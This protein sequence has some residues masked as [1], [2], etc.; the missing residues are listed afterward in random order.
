L[1]ARTGDFTLSDGDFDE[2]I[3]G[4]G[5]GDNGVLSVDGDVTLTDDTLEINGSLAGVQDGDTFDILNYDGTLGGDG[6]FTNAPLDTPFTSDGWTWEITNYDAPGIVL[7]DP[8][9][10]EVILTAEYSNT[11][12]PTGVP[13]PSELPMLV[14]GL[15]ALGAFY[16][17]NKRAKAAR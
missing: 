14:I 2:L 16:L 4:D 10:P 7:D 13:E 3:D 9:D 17:K 1:A 5:P 12:P 8:A 11:T 15:L 6:E